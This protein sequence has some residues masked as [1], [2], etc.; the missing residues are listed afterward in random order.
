MSELTFYHYMRIKQQEDEQ[1]FREAMKAAGYFSFYT[2]VEDFR[3]GLI[4][5]SEEDCS[6]YQSKLELAR[7]LFPEPERFSP[8]WSAIWD[9]FDLIFR[10]KNEVLSAIPRSRRDGEWQILLDNPYTHQQVVCYPNLPFLEAAYMYGYFQREL[11][12]HEMLRLQKVVEL[13]STNGSKET[14]LL[15]NTS[16]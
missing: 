9:E 6:L 3:K 1:L 16:V 10:C 13:L 12:P 5:Y 7:A 14:S 2:F 4:A 15:P 11:K 8:S